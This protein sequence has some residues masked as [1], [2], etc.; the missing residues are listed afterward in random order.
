MDGTSTLRVSGALHNAEL[1]QLQ[2]V[3]VAATRSTFAAI[4]GDGSVA[5]WGHPC[6]GGDSRAVRNQLKN[7]QCTQATDEAFAALLVVPSFHGATLS[8]AVTTVL[9]RSS[10]AARSRSKPLVVRLLLH[11]MMVL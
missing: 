2:P 8:V 9:Y 6:R 5:T 10:C 1:L 11:G 4:L 7:A 3:V